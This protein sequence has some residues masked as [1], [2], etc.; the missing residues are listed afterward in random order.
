M[1][2]QEKFFFIAFINFTYNTSALGLLCIKSFYKKR[3][4][5]RGIVRNGYFKAVST[6]VA[7]KKNGPRWTDFFNSLISG[8]NKDIYD[9]VIKELF[10]NK[11]ITEGEFDLAKDK[12]YL[13]TLKDKLKR[14]FL[15]AKPLS[16]KEE[17]QEKFEG[18]K[19]T[20]KIDP[21]Y[22]CIN[23]K[24]K[25]GNEK[26]YF[27]TVKYPCKRIDLQNLEI[28]RKLVKQAF[29]QICDFFHK[30]QRPFS[31]IK[32]ENI[33][34][35]ERGGIKLVDPIKESLDDAF[36]IKYLMGNISTWSPEKSELYL[37]YLDGQKEFDNEEN[38]DL[39]ELNLFAELYEQKLLKPIEAFSEYSYNIKNDLWSIGVL[40]YE[41]FIRGQFFTY[42]TDKEYIKMLS[43]INFSQDPEKP[44]PIESRFNELKK[45][46]NGKE[47]LE[48]INCF[49]KPPEKWKNSTDA[50][51]SREEVVKN[52]EKLNEKINKKIESQRHNVYK[53]QQ[54]A[55]EKKDNKNKTF[56][57]LLKGVNR[58]T[59]NNPAKVLELHNKHLTNAE[60][61]K[62]ERLINKNN[63]KISVV[64]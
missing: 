62:L 57:N 54:Q 4:T 20:M 37:K 15:R 7:S 55:L 40:I 51:Y 44:T 1:K 63:N 35:D 29:D 59:I 32:N 30:N 58:G 36:N 19:K 49:I 26:D 64:K 14:A 11:Y 33:L 3:T 42:S 21:N 12:E 41:N 56:L 43:K 8:Q 23:S 61:L 28:S 45:L 46:P 27:Y 31:D 10:I 13:H 22:I 39:L 52:L 9:K 48:I 50:V 16:K 60:R 18:E 24:N 25:E 2:I 47:V 38:L 5:D 53:R 17:N 34:V 6:H